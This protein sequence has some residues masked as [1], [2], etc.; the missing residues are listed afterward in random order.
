MAYQWLEKFR[1]SAE[2]P[3][4]HEPN[5][6]KTQQQEQHTTFII[7]DTSALEKSYTV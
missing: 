7:Q 6:E 4:D 1:L 5:C 3:G 2:T